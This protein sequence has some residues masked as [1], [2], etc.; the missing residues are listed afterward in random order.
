MAWSQSWGRV[1][2]Y[3]THALKFFQ[4]LKLRRSIELKWVAKRINGD[5]DVPQKPLGNFAQPQDYPR[6][7]WGERSSCGVSGTPLNF[8]AFHQKLDKKLALI[9]SE[10]W[11][12]KSLK[13][14]FLFD[15]TFGRFCISWICSLYDEFHVI[16]WIF[17]F[18]FQFSYF[19]T[20]LSMLE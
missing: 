14:W 5:T 8:F 12:W 7:S 15:F 2:G 13:F 4:Q 16:F 11:N 3:P 20:N 19:E 10:N 9:F 18:C 1:C 17:S 6:I